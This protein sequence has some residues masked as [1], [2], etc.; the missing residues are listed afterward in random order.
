MRGDTAD[1]IIHAEFFANRFR[2]FEVLKLRNLVISIGS[3]G[4]SYN[5]VSATLWYGAYF[6]FTTSIV[7]YSIQLIGWKIV[8]T[9]L[10]ANWFVSYQRQCTWEQR[11]LYFLW[12]LSVFSSKA[13]YRTQS[14]RRDNTMQPVAWLRCSLCLISVSES[15]CWQSLNERP[16]ELLLLRRHFYYGTPN[17]KMGLVILTTPPPWLHPIWSL[18]VYLPVRTPGY[19]F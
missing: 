3:A 11:S 8:L 15:H 19:T 12:P 1:V 17:I 16:S 14:C 10:P 2:G 9:R 18:Y 6:V 4:R 13:L 7:V 5:S